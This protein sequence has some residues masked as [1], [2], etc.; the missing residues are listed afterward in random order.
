[1]KIGV[2][3]GKGG[4]GKT[5]VSI[6]LSIVLAKEGYK[7]LLVDG[8]L[9][10]P[11]VATYFHLT[12]DTHTIEDIMA[13]ASPRDVVWTHPSGLHI[14]TPS[15]NLVLLDDQSL[16]SIYQAISSLFPY[17]DVVII[18]GPGG[19]E[20]DAQYVMMNSD[21][22]LPVTN[23]NYPALYNTLKVVYFARSMGKTVPGFVLNMVRGKDEVDVEECKSIMEV[24]LLATIPYDESVVKSV[25]RGEAVVEAFP[26]SRA[27][28]AIYDLAETLLGKP[29]SSRPRDEGIMGIVRKVIDWLMG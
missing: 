12:P 6:N 19:I 28:K 13:G 8:N 11:T 18:D 3:S 2:L 16:M 21:V 24:P 23:P 10:S 29:L 25:N 1:M 9:T 17:Y 4:V 26:N 22:I 20:K 7:T 27:A 15:F 14:L 5:L